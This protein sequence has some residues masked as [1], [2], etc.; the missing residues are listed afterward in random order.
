MDDPQW[1]FAYHPV[2]RFDGKNDGLRGRLTTK[3]RWIWIR[4]TPHAHEE[5]MI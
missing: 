2:P 5:N 1:E 4:M 3:A